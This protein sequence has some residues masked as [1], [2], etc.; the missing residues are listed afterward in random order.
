MLW[1]T[2]LAGLARFTWRRAG[3]PLIAGL[4]LRTAF[5]GQKVM[6]VLLKSA[7]APGRIFVSGVGKERSCANSRV[8]LPSSVTPERQKTD[9]RVEAARGEVQ[10][11]VL[12]FCRVATSIAAIR[13]RT[14]GLRRLA[15]RKGAKRKC[16]EN[17]SGPRT[18]N[19]EK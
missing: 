8:E 4:R 6:V 18:E 2:A 17:E 15:E 12:P 13:R 1:V 9:C 3:N 14:D 5:A 10:K 19:G 7:P 11:G 16:D